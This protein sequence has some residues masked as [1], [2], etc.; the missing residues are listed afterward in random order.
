[1]PGTLGTELLARIAEEDPYIGR[2]LVTGY[3][4]LQETIDAI[5][6]GRVHA[7]LVKPLSPD[8]LRSTVHG[9]L[10]RMWLEREIRRLARELAATNRDLGTA[11]QS[12][13]VE[14]RRAV[15][16]VSEL[17]VT[18]FRRSLDA[19]ES[20]A[21]R[22]LSGNPPGPEELRSIGLELHREAERAS[23]SCSALLGRAPYSG[24]VAEEKLDDV[25]D[26]AVR[27]LRGVSVETELASGARV[28]V[29]AKRLRCAIQN[30][31]YDA[32]QAAP[33]AALTVATR[34]EGDEALVS[35]QAA[36]R[37]DAAGSDR[38]EPSHLAQIGV[39]IA[40]R[41]VED[42]GGRLELLES[43][44][45]AGFELWLPAEAGE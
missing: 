23:R 10:D 38:E 3:A 29:D 25:V 40:R 26:A 43:E 2:I 20:T 24:A 21:A 4:D 36:P 15:G 42:S 45:G 34:V 12:H 8:H 35:I 30:L 32:I 7:Y 28:G 41:V 1:M 18:S 5:N 37:G 22:L 17:M 33:G 19:L 13:E 9:V 16:R 44:R 39:A 14:R 11:V 31:V 27:S 6:R